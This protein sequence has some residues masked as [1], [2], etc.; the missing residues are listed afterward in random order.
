VLDRRRFR[1]VQTGVTL[2]ESIRAANPDRFAWRSPPYEYEHEKWPI[3]ILA[4]SSSLRE[5]IDAGG[6]AEEIAREWV[7]GEDAFRRLRERFLMYQ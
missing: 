3:D 7:A 2:I 1:P 4:G 5:R 6:R